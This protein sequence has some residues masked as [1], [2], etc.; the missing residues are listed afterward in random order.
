MAVSYEGVL[1]T[2]NSASRGAAL[3]K[4]A[5]SLATNTVGSY[6]SVTA[7]S[8]YKGFSRQKEHENPLLMIVS[9]GS[10]EELM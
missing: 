3:W 6:T 8:F 1:H 2:E 7:S 4:Q 10:E 9:V 5:R